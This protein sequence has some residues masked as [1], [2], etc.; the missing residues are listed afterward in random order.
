MTRA[1]ICTTKFGIQGFCQ[2]FM[3][4][5]RLRDRARERTAFFLKRCDGALFSCIQFSATRHDLVHERT[6]ARKLTI[7]ALHI[8]RELLAALDHP[9]R[10]FVYDSTLR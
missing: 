4:G 8:L 3:L 7:N 1:L 2:L 10:S 9:C 6:N 5:F